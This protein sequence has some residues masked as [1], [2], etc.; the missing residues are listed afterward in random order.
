MIACSCFVPLVDCIN[1]TYT[2]YSMAENKERMFNPIEEKP[3]KVVDIIDIKPDRDTIPREVKTWM[4]KVEANQ[5]QTP[6]VFD[7]TSGQPILKPSAPTD[8]S[9]VLPISQRTFSD[10]FNK[11]VS[12]AGRWL[13][14]FVFRVIKIKK[15]KVKF[16][17]E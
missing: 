16:N 9:I 6:T 8:P 11:T 3:K 7:D 10:G 17:Q 5:T 13:S 4:E 2:F 14:E 15:G 1:L 12:D